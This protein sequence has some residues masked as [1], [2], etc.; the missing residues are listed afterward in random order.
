MVSQR[1]PLSWV[2]SV[3]A[4]ML[5]VIDEM[6]HAAGWDAEGGMR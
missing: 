2:A 3:T 6:L 5:S 1:A 4:V